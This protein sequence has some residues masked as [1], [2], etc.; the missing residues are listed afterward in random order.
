[1]TCFIYFGIGMGVSLYKRYV[2]NLISLKLIMCKRHSSL[3]W[4]CE[5][6]VV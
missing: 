3:P 2:S 4:Y 1:M 6:A 5:K